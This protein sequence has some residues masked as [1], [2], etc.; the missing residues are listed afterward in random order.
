MNLSARNLLDDRLDTLLVDLLNRHG[1]APRLLKLEVTGSAIMTDPVRAKTL[2]D[3]L[4]AAGVGLPIDDFGAGYTSLGQLKHLPIDQLKIDRWFV[5]TMTSDASNA[6]SV[7]SVIELGHNLG[8]TAVSPKAWRPS[9]TFP[10]STASAAT[11]RRATIWPAPCPPT[12]SAPGGPAGQDSK[13]PSRRCQCPTRLTSLTS[14]GNR[15]R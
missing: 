8:L 12:L 1:V 3:R 5:Q 4:H 14:A 10:R 13:C 9:S 11:S 2:L 6:L 15:Q 7:R